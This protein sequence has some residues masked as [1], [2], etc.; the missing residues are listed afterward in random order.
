MIEFQLTIYMCSYCT[1]VHN[2]SEDCR[3]HEESEHSTNATMETVDPPSLDRMDD[4]RPADNPFGIADDG[5]GG[6]GVDVKPNIADEPSDVQRN[7][8]DGD[9]DSVNLIEDDAGD[10]DY[11]EEN[12]KK[13]LSPGSKSQ[14]TNAK[15]HEC[16]PCRRTFS[17]VS[18][19]VF[20]KVD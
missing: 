19:R 14:T 20:W 2:A 10:E 17:S 6:I 7:V 4:T 18:G 11:T 1:R 5:G 16:K 13:R 9:D 12:Q 15:Q 8:M 3:Q